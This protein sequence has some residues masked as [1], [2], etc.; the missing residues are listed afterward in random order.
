M[1]MLSQRE[2]V[3]LSFL[4]GNFPPRLFITLFNL[5]R[6]KNAK[7]TAEIPDKTTDPTKNA[8]NTCAERH[9]CK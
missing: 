7:G 8:G 1:Q 4:C 9:R 2:V 5:G 3:H 6:R